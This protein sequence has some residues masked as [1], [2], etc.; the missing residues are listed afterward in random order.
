M[1]RTLV[2][3]DPSF[4]VKVYKLARDGHPV[5]H[6]AKA[7]GTTCPT[8]N[9]WCKRRP[10]LQAALDEGRAESAGGALGNSLQGYLYQHLSP[11]LQQLWDKVM[12]FE[13]LQ[14]PA[15][16]VQAL[17]A[18]KGKRTRQRLTI[19]A[20]GQTLFNTSRALRMV[21]VPKRTFDGWVKDDP[22]FAELVEELEWHQE[23]FYK[24]RFNGLVAR[25]DTAATIHAVKTKLRHRGYN[26]RLEVTHTGNVTTQ[27]EVALDLT[28]LDLDAPTR[29][30]LLA[31]LRAR[32]QATTQP[33]ALPGPA[34]AIS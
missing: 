31:A 29:R 1:P 32:Q 27:H 18:D 9:R 19:H 26:D 10:A 16:K 24:S 2:K 7:L 13:H 34:D 11:E 5:T 30:A 14:N 23:E 4:Y 3:F 33:A 12:E 6:I 20:L 8:F 25:G 17:L 15:E 21:G 22:G 28:E